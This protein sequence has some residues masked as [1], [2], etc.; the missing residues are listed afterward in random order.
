[1]LDNSYAGSRVVFL[2]SS[3]IGKK[4]QAA[5]RLEENS[6]KNDLPVSTPKDKNEKNTASRE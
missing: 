1:M 4:R 5:E 3:P 6:K 2:D